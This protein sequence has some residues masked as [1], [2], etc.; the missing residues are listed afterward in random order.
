MDTLKAVPSIK[1]NISN[2]V[3]RIIIA[4]LLVLDVEYAIP[5]VMGANI[6]TSLTNTLVSFSQVSDR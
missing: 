4:Y 1:E 6:G 3:D 5:L 2:T